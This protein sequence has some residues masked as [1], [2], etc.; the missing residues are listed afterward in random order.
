MMR[1]TLSK[2]ASKFLKNQEKAIQLRIYAAL[3]G[4]TKKPPT[5]DI[6]KMKG[7]ANTYRLRIGT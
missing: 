2:K 7:V 1:I 4:L 3:K 6:Q 5:G